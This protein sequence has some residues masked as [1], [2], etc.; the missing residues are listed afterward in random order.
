MRVG[1][2]T[3]WFPRGAAYVSKQYRDILETEHDVHIYARGGERF[4]K[5]DP[6]WDNDSVTLG[7]TPVNGLAVPILLLHFKKWLE[8]KKI[9]MVIFN[10][11]RYFKPILLCN[12]M[13]IITGAYIDYYT[14]DTIP[15][16]GVYDFLLCNTTRH[17]DAFSWHPNCL[18]VPWGTDVNLFRPP[19]K[20]KRYDQSVVFFHSCGMNPYRKG[21]D[22]VIRAFSKVKQSAKLIIHT[23]IDLRKHIPW[24]QEFLRREQLGDRVT[25][26]H[27]TVDPPGLYHLGDVY[28]YPSRLDGLGLTIAEAFAC[29]LPV[30][31]TDEPPM[32]QFV[33]SE[34]G[35]LVPVVRRTKRS[36]GYY[37]PEVLPSLG[38]LANAMQSY[39]EERS[40]AEIKDK[41]RQYATSNLNWH[42]NARLLPGMLTNIERTEPSVKKRAEQLALQH[43][44]QRLYIRIYE[45]SPNMF[46]CILRIR[47]ILD[48]VI[49][50]WRN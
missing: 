38:V 9:E 43:D 11:Q 5:G 16:F 37:W 21:T 6:D 23:Q 20:K 12:K 48:F 24:F 14:N 46:Q 40:L 22:L 27:R 10:E 25:V 41:A 50:R 17:Y 34:L 8:E 47:S 29:G 36:D 18:Y 44:S 32:N 39:V 19:H 26:I 3:S 31:T 2:V 35:R 13:G 42:K 1:I 4:A 28:V 33:N 30:I 49:N 15:I 7:E 45:F